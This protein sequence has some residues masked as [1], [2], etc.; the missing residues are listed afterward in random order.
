MK[1]VDESVSRPL[2]YYENNLCG[3]VSLLKTMTRHAVRALIFS[4]S[5]TV[6][7]HPARLPVDEQS[8][9][10]PASPYGRTKAFIEDLLH[11]V[12]SAEPDWRIVCLRYF[13][14]VGAHSSGRIGEDPAGIPN[15]LMPYVM[16]VAVGRRDRLTIHGEDYP[17]VDGTCVRD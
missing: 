16:Q 6:Y 17:T 15:N 13:N 10:S 14:P 12:A 1:S 9:M 8:S 5:C 3:T 7:G 11:D 2:A 4:S